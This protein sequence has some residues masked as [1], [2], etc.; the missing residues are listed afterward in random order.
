MKVDLPLAP[1]YYGSLRPYPAIGSDI[2][3]AYSPSG[4]GHDHGER[5]YRGA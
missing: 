3:N 2:Q 5:V 1:P 4:Q